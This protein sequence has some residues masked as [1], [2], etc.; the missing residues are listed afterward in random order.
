MPKAVY[1]EF[2]G[3]RHELDIPDGWTLL[4]AAQNAGIE[5][6]EGECGGSCACATC[7]ILVEEAFIDRLDAMDANEDMILDE[8]ACE[9][10]ANSRLACRILMRPDLDGL[11]VRLPERQS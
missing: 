10:L 3:T 11:T 1:I 2:G 6:L 9:R 4:Q 5:A 8:T 7:H